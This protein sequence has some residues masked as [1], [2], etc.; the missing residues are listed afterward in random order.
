MFRRKKK[1]RKVKGVAYEVVDNDV[2]IYPEGEKPVALDLPAGRS[3]Y[4]LA[5]YYMTHVHN[6]KHKDKK[7]VGNFYYKVDKDDVI[8]VYRESGELI[9]EEK[10]VSENEKK[11]PRDKAV[12]IIINTTK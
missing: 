11:Y 4:A 2:W 8:K 9:K 10:L 3:A 12:S 6:K 5:Y 1:K 7:K